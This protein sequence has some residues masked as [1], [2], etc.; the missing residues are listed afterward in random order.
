MIAGKVQ[1]NV[2]SLQ[3]HL[4]LRDLA[5]LH[6][7]INAVEGPSIAELVLVALYRFVGN[8]V[9]LP[10]LP[11][12][13]VKP[14]EFPAVGFIKLDVKLVVGDLLLRARDQ[15]NLNYRVGR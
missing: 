6:V 3:L 1:Q 4:N 5:F 8:G 15:L 9:Q 10:V 7:R 2:V 14:H 13:N 12:L 11:Q